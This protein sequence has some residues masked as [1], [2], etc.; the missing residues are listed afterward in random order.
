MHIS[1]FDTYEQMIEAIKDVTRDPQTRYSAV[2]TVTEHNP[3]GLRTLEEWVDWV[4]GNQKSYLKG[5]QLVR[6]NCG[7]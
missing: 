3:Y 5:A 2:G 6:G 7:E 4:S 1:T